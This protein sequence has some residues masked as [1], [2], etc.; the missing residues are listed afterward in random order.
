MPEDAAKIHNLFYKIYSL[1]SK[2]LLQ[3]FAITQ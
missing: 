2:D 1:C 3:P